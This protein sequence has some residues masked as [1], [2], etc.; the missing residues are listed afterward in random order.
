MTLHLWVLFSILFIALSG[1]SHTVEKINILS[2]EKILKEELD[3]MQMEEIN[4]FESPSTQCV[5]VRAE[6]PL[7]L[8]MEGD[9]LIGGF[10]P[11][12]YMA[13]ELQHSYQTKPQVTPCSG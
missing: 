5:K 1:F 12:H 8:Q 7:A 13:T 9:V 10:F 3:D 4:D 11:L 2:R 6:E